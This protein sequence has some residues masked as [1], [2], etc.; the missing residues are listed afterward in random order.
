MD[1]DESE[2]LLSK[3]DSKLPRATAL[4]RLADL[5][6]R[7]GR[8]VARDVLIKMLLAE[9]GLLQATRTNL[10]SI[11]GRS[12]VSVETEV[13]RIYEPRG[14]GEAETMKLDVTDATGRAKLTLS[15]R[16]LSE[17]KDGRISVGSRIVLQNVEAVPGPRLIEIEAGDWSRL[18]AGDGS[19]ARKASGMSPGGSGVVVRGTV[20][21]FSEPRRFMRADGSA[22]LVSD[23]AIDNGGQEVTVTLW[24]D[25]AAIAKRLTVGDCVC[26]SGLAARERMGR[27]T[28]NSSRSTT[29]RFE[30]RARA[31]MAG[32]SDD[33]SIHGSPKGAPL[34][35]AEPGPATRS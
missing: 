1:G 32:A 18:E 25:A 10:G 20:V 8:L 31:G 9:H 28:L 7:M 5:D 3:L 13:T 22:G 34:G 19:S 26:L 23:I 27:A 33:A 35:R 17:V 14:R 29:I 21:S 24:D 12:M 16:H 15:G 30:E 6:M 2:T 4:G 11:T